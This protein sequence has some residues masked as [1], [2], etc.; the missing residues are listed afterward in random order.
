MK[1]AYINGIGSLLIRCTCIVFLKACKMKKQYFL[2][3]CKCFS[4]FWPAF[5]ERKVVLH[6]MCKFFY[7]TPSDTQRKERQGTGQ[8]ERERKR[9]M[10]CCVL[11]SVVHSPPLPHPT[12]SLPPCV[13]LHLPVAM[14]ITTRG[15]GVSPPPHTLTPFGHFEAAAADL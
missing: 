2:D 14:V 4:D 13:P 12:I 8:G 15:K 9:K 3:E 6:S 10:G 1:G 5:L 11:L 7:R